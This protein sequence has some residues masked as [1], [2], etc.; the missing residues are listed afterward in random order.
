M[1]SLSLPTSPDW[2]R[3]ALADLPGLLTDHHLCELKAAAMNESIARRWGEKFPALGRTMIDL[4]KEERGHGARVTR[5]LED[6]GFAGAGVNWNPRDRDGSQILTPTYAAEL[7]RRVRPGDSLIDLL[8]ISSLIEARSCERFRLLALEKPPHGLTA[9]YEDLFAAEA[10]HHR[11]F[12]GLAG[13]LFGEDAVRPRLTE[14]SLVEAEVV[15]TRPAGP[16]VHD[17]VMPEARERIRE[18]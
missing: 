5:F 4:A 8:L 7:R 3:N 6:L 10:R 15:A 9:F 11:L 13:D 17:G 2:A 16:R 1:L 12:V 18:A 14:L